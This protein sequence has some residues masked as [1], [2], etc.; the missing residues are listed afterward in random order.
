MKKKIP[1]LWA[2]PTNLPEVPACGRGN[3]IISVNV[4]AWCPMCVKFHNHGFV[5]DN[6]RKQHRASHCVP[7]IWNEYYLRL[8]RKELKKL[9]K[10]EC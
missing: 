6:T 7:K 10:G 1:T 9:V 8:D 2:V 4:K 3:S 5:L